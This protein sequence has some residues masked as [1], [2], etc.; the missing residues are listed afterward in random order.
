MVA[1]R[2]AGRAAQTLTDGVEAEA[3]SAELP[4]RLGDTSQEE[5]PWERPLITFEMYRD[6]PEAKLPPGIRALLAEQAKKP[7]VKHHVFPQEFKSFFDKKGINIHEWVMVLLLEDHLRIHRGAYG[8][9]WNADWRAWIKTN[10]ITGNAEA[11]YRFAGEMVYRYCL[12]GTLTR[13]RCD[14]SFPTPER[15]NLLPSDAEND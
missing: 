3:P 4:E 12:S 14:L 15:V 13:Y 7:H 2:R 9:P 6:P 10:N 5:L 8:G 1:P 11:I